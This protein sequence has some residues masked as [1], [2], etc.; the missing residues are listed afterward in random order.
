MQNARPPQEWKSFVLFCIFKDMK[1]SPWFFALSCFTA[2]GGSTGPAHRARCLGN[3][4]NSP[5]S[6]SVP[7]HFRNYDGLWF[8]F[9]TQ[10]LFYSFC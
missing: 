4:A 2:D 6:H 7:P 1:R 3:Q 9:F 10:L 8:S 5:T